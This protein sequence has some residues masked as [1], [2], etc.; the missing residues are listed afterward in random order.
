MGHRLSWGADDRRS[1]TCVTR[2][3]ETHLGT[4]LTVVLLWPILAK[5]SGSEHHPGTRFIPQTRCQLKRRRAN[6]RN[7]SA[8]DGHDY[9]RSLH[10]GN[11]SASRDAAELSTSAGD[12]RVCG[13][14]R[15][16][17]NLVDIPDT[18]ARHRRR[19]H[20]VWEMATFYANLGSKVPRSKWAEGLLPGADRDLSNACKNAS[21]TMS[22][23]SG[24][25]E[26][27]RRLDRR[28]DNPIEAV[29][30]ARAKSD[31]KRLIRSSSSVLDVVPVIRG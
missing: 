15:C 27:E 14:H 10:F 1:N 4:N 3:E 11:W 26:Y 6:H 22:Q 12:D 16:R 30:K 17:W 24:L 29:L 7:R 23:R 28:V 2:K 18:L 20:R 5:P 9:V 31:T 19:V 25:F 8:R 21:A 13:Q